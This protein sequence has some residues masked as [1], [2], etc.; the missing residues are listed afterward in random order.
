MNARSP[1]LTE[2]QEAALL[3][4]SRELLL[5]M[6]RLIERSKELTREHREIAAELRM[7]RKDEKK[8][9]E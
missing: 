7:K 1:K 9:A 8:S 5:E 6:E 4:R 3:K 2:E